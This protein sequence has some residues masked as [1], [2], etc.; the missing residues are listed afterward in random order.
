MV[1]APGHSLTTL[2]PVS[3]P[4]GAPS[5]LS[6][7]CCCSRSVTCAVPPSPARW[8]SAHLQVAESSSNR[9]LSTLPCCSPSRGPAAGQGTAGYK[10]PEE[11]SSRGR[12]RLRCTCDPQEGDRQSN[13]L[14]ARTTWRG[15]SGRQTRLSAGPCPSAAAGPRPGARPLSLGSPP[16]KWV[17][18]GSMR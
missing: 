15:G 16:V 9:T 13:V 14:K 17:S 11:L 7:R 12:A 1:C 8:P 5:R 2:V 18:A 4:G 3:E 6:R 10:A